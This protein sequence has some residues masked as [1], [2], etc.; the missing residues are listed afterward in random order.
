M[1]ELLQHQVQ[2]VQYVLWQV[3]P[4]DLERFPLL[5][6]WPLQLAACLPPIQLQPYLSA[7]QASGP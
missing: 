2:Q 3:Y 6:R 4:R 7:L 5:R 1:V